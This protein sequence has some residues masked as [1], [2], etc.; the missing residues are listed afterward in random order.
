[1]KTLE[2]IAFKTSKRLFKRSEGSEL[3]NFRIIGI[4]E[5]GLPFKQECHLMKKKSSP[6]G[7][8]MMTIETSDEMI[9]AKICLKYR[10]VSFETINAFS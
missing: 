8:A 1:L 7:G 9:G 3:V 2:T 10:L 5:S 4:T 6:N